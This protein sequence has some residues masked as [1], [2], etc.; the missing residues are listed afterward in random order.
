MAGL[1]MGL[2]WRVAPL[3]GAGQR[4]NDTHEREGNSYS[5]IKK[6]TQQCPDRALGAHTGAS[7][8]MGS[9]RLSRIDLD[10]RRTKC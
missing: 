5:Q 8:K 1:A 6:S 2:T 7:E 4:E 3:T 9:R 10:V